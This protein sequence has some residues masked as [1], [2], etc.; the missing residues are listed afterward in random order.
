MSSQQFFIKQTYPSYDLDFQ[1]RAEVFYRTSSLLIKQSIDAQTLLKSSQVQ[2]SQN[3]II[4]KHLKTESDENETENK[5]Q[6][7][8]L[9]KIRPVSVYERKASAN[10]VSIRQKFIDNNNIPLQETEK[11]FEDINRENC[12]EATNNNLNNLMKLEKKIIGFRPNSSKNELEKIRSNEKLNL[13]NA[14]YI[15]S[16]FFA[17]NNNIKESVTMGISASSLKTASRHLKPELYIKLLKTKGVNLKEK[18]EKMKLQKKYLKFNF[19]R[20]NSKIKKNE[21]FVVLSSNQKEKEKVPIIHGSD[22]LNRKKLENEELIKNDHKL[23]SSKTM[24]I[25]RAQSIT[26]GSLKKKQFKVQNLKSK[27][28]KTPLL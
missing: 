27:Q 7:K 3:P 17:Y 28:K 26:E 5:K 6:L 18:E 20:R 16:F 21:F 4:V 8:Q 9:M 19:D 12:N 15:K 10:S 23:F 13:H 2:Q 25:Y 22:K 14:D 24:N 1:S 11:N